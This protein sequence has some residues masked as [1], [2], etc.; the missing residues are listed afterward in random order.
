M[1]HP[2][3][4][5]PQGQ[6]ANQRLSAAGGRESGGTG[7]ALSLLSDENVS[8]PDRGR[9]CRT[10]CCTECHRTFA[11]NRLILGDVCFPSIKKMAKRILKDQSRKE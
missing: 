3:K 9:G 8:E 10:L 5:N 1:K 4:A 7:H 2:K 11:L 6:K